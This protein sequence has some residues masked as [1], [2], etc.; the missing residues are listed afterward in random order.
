MNRDLLQLAMQAQRIFQS[1]YGYKAPNICDF[2]IDKHDLKVNAAMEEDN[3]LLK[4]LEW[5]SFV[6]WKP[7]LDVSR[8]DV[9]LYVYFTPQDIMA[10]NNELPFIEHAS[11]PQWKID[12]DNVALFMDV[13]AHVANFL[14]CSYLFSVE[15]IPST[16]HISLQNQV[17]QFVFVHKLFGYGGRDF[18][19]PDFFANTVLYPGLE[20]GERKLSSDHEIRD[21]Q[22][23]AHRFMQHL[24]YKFIMNKNY[25]GF[26][27]TVK[28]FFY[29]PQSRK[30]SEINTLI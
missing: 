2:I 8:S 29:K 25:S 20:R 26:Y 24:H 10:V 9:Y 27:E 1:I 21:A 4:Y 30:V 13:I 6:G 23:Y 5:V 3:D 14:H 11:E 12:Q 28:G 18:F 22:L 16:F 17:D 15:M 19:V 7:A